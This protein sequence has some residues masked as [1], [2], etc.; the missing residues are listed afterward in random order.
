MVVRIQLTIKHIRGHTFTVE[1]DVD[2][3]VLGLKVQIWES[4]KI[5]IENQRLVFSGKEL[6]D[7]VTLSQMNIGDNATIFLVESLSDAPQQ[8]QVETPQV[9]IENP[10]PAGPIVDV[11]GAIYQQECATVCQQQGVP[12]VV[13]V[14]PNFY[15][16][17]QIDTALSEERI[18]SV[19]DL[20]F[21]TRLYCIFGFI[22]SV[23]LAFFYYIFIIPVILYICG[24]FGTRKINRCLLACPLLLSLFI[25]ISCLWLTFAYGFVVILFLLSIFHFIIFS[26]FCKLMSRIRQ[27]TCQEWWQTRTRIQARGRCC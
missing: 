5:A 26:G 27:L 1:T 16:Q 3:E 19:I 25:A 11:N 9:T 20:A 7:N 24:Y 14:N 15:G 12:I 21:W 13:P 4:Q 8:A 17:M 23:L 6:A 18:Q 10:T 2:S 22:W